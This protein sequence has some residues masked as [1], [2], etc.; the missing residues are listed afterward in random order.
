[1]LV[2]FWEHQVFKGTVLQVTA[3]REENLPSNAKYHPYCSMLAWPDSAKLGLAISKW[4]EMSPDWCTV[5]WLLDIHIH[6]DVNRYSIFLTRVSVF[7]LIGFHLS[8]E[9]FTTDLHPV[10]ASSIKKSNVSISMIPVHLQS[11]AQVK[12]V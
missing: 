11:S 7:K 8:S 3:V 9:C 2:A 12:Y 4:L 1:M 10:I 6:W 5:A